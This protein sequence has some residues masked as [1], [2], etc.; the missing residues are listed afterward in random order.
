MKI[1]VIL[2]GCVLACLSA[3]NTDKRDVVPQK[4][5]LQTVCK[6]DFLMAA[7]IKLALC[8]TII[9]ILDS[10]MDTLV[11]LVDIKNRHYLGKVGVLGQGPNEFTAVTSFVAWRGDCLLLD[12]NTTAFYRLHVGEHSYFEKLFQ[13]VKNNSRFHSRIVPLSDS[14]YVATGV[15]EEGRFCLLDKKGEIICDKLEE[16]PWK[17]KKERD[18]SGIVKSQLYS[19]NILV[20][21]SGTKM[22]AY[23]KVGDLLSF[24]NVDGDSISLFKKRYLS[25]PEEYR[26]QD[27]HFLG[28]SRETPFSYIDGV[29]TENHIFLLYSGRTVQEYDLRTFYGNQVFVFNWDGEKVAK[30]TTDKDL[31]TIEI[32]PTGDALYAIA[33][34]PEPTLMYCELPEL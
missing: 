30:L 11:H 28:F 24:Y 5:H 9:A 26:Y 2:L 25:F 17:D 12:P 27:N 22:L 18:M 15:Y 23:T 4:L 31:S 3:C 21:P 7:P 19:S 29:A 20:A 6:K 14:L 32:S 34:T 16:Y 10:K 8:D 1:N 13:Y 33:Y